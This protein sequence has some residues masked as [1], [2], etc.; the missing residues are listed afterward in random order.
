[1][2]PFEQNVF[3]ESK[4]F[5]GDAELHQHSTL[6][7]DVLNMLHVPSSRAVMGFWPIIPYAV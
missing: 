6:L 4:G 7:H 3:A 2:A 1:M 5:L